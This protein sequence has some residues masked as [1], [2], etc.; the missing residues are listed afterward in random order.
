MS[1]TQ[2]SM[3]YEA[4]LPFCSKDKSRFGITQPFNHQEH[5]YATTGRILIRVPKI[6]EIEHRPGQPSD[7]AKPIPTGE[8]YIPVELPP[9][10]Q[11]FTPSTSRCKDCQ[12]TGKITTCRNCQGTGE[13]ECLHCG[14]EGECKECNGKGAY[15]SASSADPCEECDGTGTIEQTFAVS[16]NHGK[17][18]VN[19]RYLQLAHTLPNVRLYMLDSIT[20]LRIEFDGGEGALMPTLQSENNGTPII[21]QWKQQ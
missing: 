2:Q 16:L 13:V 8:N 20:T 21:E 14:H 10:W 7:P 6:C 17:A 4:L 18:S 15:T 12:G 1:T 9:N 3:T 19:L 5:T 11:S